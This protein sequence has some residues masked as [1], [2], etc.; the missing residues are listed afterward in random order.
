MA[1]LAHTV[2]SQVEPLIRDVVEHQG[3]QLVDVT[4]QRES[5]GWVLRVFIDR[6]GGVSVEDCGQVSSQL[7]DILD[8]HDVI[9]HRYH[10]EVSSPGVNRPLKNEGDFKRFLGSTVRVI[11]HTAIENRKRFKGV[12]RSCDEGIILLQEGCRQWQIPL[13]SVRKAHL[14]QDLADL[15]MLGKTGKDTA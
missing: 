12:L 13:R 10:L 2:I 7:G 8:V 11:T 9:P 6:E 1:D 15:R 3:M 14:D 5:H 4:Y